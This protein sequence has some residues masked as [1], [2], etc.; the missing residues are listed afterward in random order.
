MSG[1]LRGPLG[2]LFDAR[3]LLTDVSG[4]GNNWGE[5]YAVYGQQHRDALSDIFRA[6]ASGAS[7]GSGGLCGGGGPRGKAAAPS[8]PRGPHSCRCAGIAPPAAG[9][10]L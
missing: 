5:G 7:G 3:Q 10:G 4:S 2:E 1:V 6:Q 9:G 8:H